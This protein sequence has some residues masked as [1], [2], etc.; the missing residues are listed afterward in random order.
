MKK[1]ERG[2]RPE[3]LDVFNNYDEID[4]D[5]SAMI[6]QYTAEL[7]RLA[8]LTVLE[9]ERR[10]F[11]KRVDTLHIGDRAE[12]RS[13]NDAQ[14]LT[15]LKLVMLMLLLICGGICWHRTERW[16]MA[17]RRGGRNQA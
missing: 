14:E 17:Q 4:Y 5:N 2:V 1:D 13:R 8:K 12:E 6:E 7:E 9:G 15:G 11:K 16:W 10:A 3:P